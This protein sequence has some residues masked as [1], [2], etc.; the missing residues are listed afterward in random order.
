MTVV[1]TSDGIRDTSVPSGELLPGVSPL[2]D[3][4]ELTWSGPDGR[5]LRAAADLHPL[6]Q[7]S[8]CR[9]YPGNRH[10]V[11]RA[12]DIVEALPVAELY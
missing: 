12:A 10:A 11:R 1:R 6:P 9:G 7:H 8:L 4:K 5:L 2:A 3:D